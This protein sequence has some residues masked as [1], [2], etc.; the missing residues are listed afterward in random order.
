MEYEEKSLKCI[1]EFHV[2]MLLKTVL[3]ISHTVSDDS[4]NNF[5]SGF[6]I[7]NGYVNMFMKVNKNL[8]PQNMP[9]G[10]LI[11]SC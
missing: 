1:T 5:V 2:R 9:F 8:Q 3:T 10:M 7:N 4:R 6:K 11:L